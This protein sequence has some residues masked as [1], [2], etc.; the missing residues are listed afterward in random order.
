[1]KICMFSWSHDPKDHRI[2][3]KEARSL[4]KDGHEVTIL[5]PTDEIEEMT[6]IKGVKIEIFARLQV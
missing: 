1:M 2:F 5:A 6:V 4:Q 3:D